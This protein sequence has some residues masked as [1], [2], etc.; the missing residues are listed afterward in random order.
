[1]DVVTALSEGVAITVS[2]QY[3]VLTT[4]QAANL[5]RVSRPTLVRLLEVGEIPFDQPGRHRRIRLADLLAYQQRARWARA[6]GLDEMV[7]VSEHSGDR[8][9]GGQHEV[10]AALR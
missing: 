6:A 2:P 7:S 10:P 8:A 5:L 9:G 3:T 4:G 1:M